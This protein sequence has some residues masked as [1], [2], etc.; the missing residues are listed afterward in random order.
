M[1]SKW[2]PSIVFLQLFHKSKTIWKLK[3][4]LNKINL[5]L[6]QKKYDLLDFFLILGK[7]EH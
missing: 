4:Y 6:Q 1:K 7:T 3:V 5:K 2:E